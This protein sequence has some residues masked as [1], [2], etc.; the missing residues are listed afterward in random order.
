MASHYYEGTGIL[1]LDHV[2]PV[3]TALFGNFSLNPNSP[4]KGEA[5]IALDSEAS[6]TQW[7]D[8]HEALLVL[9]SQLDLPCPDDETERT[10]EETLLLL[11]QHFHPEL[12]NAMLLKSGTFEINDEAELSVLFFLATCFNDGHGLQEIRFEGGWRCSKPRL[13]EF[14]GNGL[15]ISR[16]VRIHGNSSDYVSLGT[17]LR[18]AI[19]EQDVN[20]ATDLLY[21]DLSMRLTGISDEVIRRHVMT[22]FTDRLQAAL[23][24]L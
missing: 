23:A 15:F 3:I 14:G 21:A 2:T 6:H 13:F 22:V 24:R 7:R 17:N 8:I 1:V 19:L 16:E 10:L 9:S 18:K 20:T 11:A 12:P 4:G 5:Y